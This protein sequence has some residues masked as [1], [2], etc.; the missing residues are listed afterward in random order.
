MNIDNS[1]YHSFAKQMTRPVD[2]TDLREA[3]GQRKNSYVGS[4]APSLV[5]TTVT[6]P[7]HDDVAGATKKRQ[8]GHGSADVKDVLRDIFEKKGNK[9]GAG[10]RPNGH[11]AVQ[12][13]TAPQA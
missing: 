9:R 5:S 11:A 1:S 6:G 10:A 2:V 3:L 12:P 13:V 7:L 8:V 4:A